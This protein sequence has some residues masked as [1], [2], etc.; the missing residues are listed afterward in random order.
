MLV[1]ETLN[2]RHPKTPA[3]SA[4]RSHPSTFAVSANRFWEAKPYET[5]RFEWQDPWVL[6]TLPQESADTSKTRSKRNA[7]VSY[8]FFGRSSLGLRDESLFVM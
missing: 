6:L 7:G 2:H 1:P 8:G 3:T 4:A 5:L